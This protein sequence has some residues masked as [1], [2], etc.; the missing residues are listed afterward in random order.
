MAP[1][2]LGLPRDLTALFAALD[3]EQLA[4]FGQVKIPLLVARGDPWWWARLL[5]ALEAGRPEEI[6]AVLEHAQLA[7][8]R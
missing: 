1:T 8:V 5:E 2:V 3:A 6:D 4:G 7:F